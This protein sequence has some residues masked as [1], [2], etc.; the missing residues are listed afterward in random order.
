MEAIIDA[1]DQ[2]KII[3]LVFSANTEK[4]QW[5]KD[6]IKLALEEK[7]MIIPFRIQDVY[8]QRSLKLLKVRCQ[9]M[10][11]FTP[12]LEKPDDE[13]WGRKNR[14][15]IF[16]SWDD[17]SAYCQWLSQKTGLRF[18]LPT[19]AQ[20]EK[21]ARG[22]DQRKYPW[23]N[24]EPDKN[25]ANFGFDI[26]KTTPVDSYPAGASPFGLLDMAGNVWEWCSDWYEAD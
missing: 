20:W 25:L 19:E 11:A 6:E 7:R 22:N 3:V 15:V 5:V 21:A 14:P 10:H 12:P 23:G 2:A 26:D 4:S 13:D 16:V 9:W 8:P 1:V 18:N 17:A 24:Q